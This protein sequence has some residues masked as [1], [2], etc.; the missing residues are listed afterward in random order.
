M[1]IKAPPTPPFQR[2]AWLESA[3]KARIPSSPSQRDG[4]CRPSVLSFVSVRHNLEYV[5][6]FCLSDRHLFCTYHLRLA[7][8][9]RQKSQ[10]SRDHKLGILPHLHCSSKRHNCQPALRRK[11]EGEKG[12]FRISSWHKNGTR[13]AKSREESARSNARKDQIL[14]FPSS[15]IGDFDSESFRSNIIKF[16][17]KCVRKA[18]KDSEKLLLVLIIVD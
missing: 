1:R 5:S 15:Q 12:Q 16:S 13:C 2:G 17:E 3:N 4:G 11:R 14:F 9:F 6:L 10:A 7:F 8:R 18:K